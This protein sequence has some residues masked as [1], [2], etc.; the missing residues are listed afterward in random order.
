MRRSTVDLE[1]LLRVLCGREIASVIVGV[2]HGAPTTTQDLDIVP[3]QSEAN[4]DRLLEALQ[5]HGTLVRDPPGRR[6][7]PSPVT[8]GGLTK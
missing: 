8:L 7:E 3:E 2:L 1:C 5:A 6:L 4:L